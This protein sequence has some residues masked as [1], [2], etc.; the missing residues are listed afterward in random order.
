MQNMLQKTFYLFLSALLI[1]SNIQAQTSVH[2]SLNIDYKNAL[3]LFTEGKYAAATSVFQEVEKRNYTIVDK[4]DNNTDLSLLKADA[5]YYIAVCALILENDDAQELLQRFIKQHP[6]N[7]KTKLAYYQIGKY[8]YQKADYQNA[9]EWFKKVNTVDLSGDDNVE[10]KF[11][12]AYSYFI[13][14]DYASAK[15]L[16]GLIKDKKSVYAEQATYYYAIIS[17]INKDYKL[18]LSNFEKLKGSKNYEA[19]YPYYISAI[20]F[21]DQ[22]YDDVL[23]YTIPILEQTKQTNEVEMLRIVAASYFAKADYVNAIKYYELFMAKDNNS[24]QNS[25]D[26]YQIGYTYYKLQNYNKSIAQL[27]KLVSDTTAYS[28][29]GLYTLGDNYIKNK[30]KQSARNAFQVSSKLNFDRLLQEDAL[31]NFAKLSYE[32][33][34]HNIALD[35]IQNFIKKYPYSDKRNEAKTLHA[36]ILIGSKNYKTAVDILEAMPDKSE[37]AKEAYQK[38]TYFR[39][40]EF[41][42]ER[43]FENAISLFLRSL[44]YP[45][46]SEIEALATYWCAESMYEV[47]KYSEAVEK[48]AEF[49]S[50]PA[51]K[52]LSIYNY[53]NYA[54]GYAA[55]EGEN[56]SKAAVYFDK[57]LDKSD[58]DANIKTD[59]TIRLADAYF[60]AKSYSNAL[61][62]YNKIIS[63]NAKA[64]DYALFQR[65]IIQGIQNAP[66]AKIATLQSLLNQFPNSN[67]A[68]DAGFEIAY[69]YFLI[70]Q[71]E[72]AKSD[73]QNLI[74]KYP[75]TS[76]IPRALITIGLVDYDQKKD[77]EAIE[78]FKK[79]INDYKSTDEA[80]QALK[81]IERIYIDGGNA[82]EFINYANTTSI[83]NYST[84]EQDNIMFQAAYNRYLKSDWNGTIESVNAYYDKFPKPIKDKQSRFIRA[85]S[86]KNAEKYAAAIIDYE[87]ILNDWTS[88]WTEKALISISKIY[89]NNKQYNEAIVHLKKLEISSE[90]KA[91]YN[92]AI[93]NL[94]IA[95]AGIMVPDQTLKY[96]DII[97]TYEKSSD[98]D[99]LRASLFS[100]KAYLLQSDTT[101]ALKQLESVVKTNKSIIAAEAK[102]NIAEVL[103]YKK[104]YK[105]AQKTCFDLINNMPNYDYWVAKSFLLLADIYKAQN[106]KTQAIATLKS[107][108]DN[109]EGKDEI[110]E[111]A[112]QKLE[113][114]NAK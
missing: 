64:E 51:S 4:I 66:D 89:M 94:L 85:E 16:F 45:K 7:P 62:Y 35:A 65:G 105:T 112:K 63:Q 43:A 82:T 100:G 71:G 9:L 58:K 6:E 111:T 22:R 59:A 106:D 77:E 60:G 75:R 68:D 103:Y 92:Y 38:A 37:E 74:T 90:Y 33:E 30:N 10:Y 8:Y 79:V 23:K 54:L 78:V 47:R 53:A 14:E 25:Q 3:E 49:L 67:Y 107:I 97:K 20:Y 96:A 73:L 39:G 44:N 26:A 108:I 28:Q 36:K 50:Q 76:Y 56:Y 114:L 101:S 13:N 87:Y 41:F 27:G 102:Y 48:Y 95:Y 46:D 91:N 109:Y 57:F 72:K 21:L 113:I 19:S 34:F 2:N 11:K 1:V 104:D 15:P 24:T 93:N 70:G 12:T 88:E 86:Y 69:T 81:L 80:Q 32:L 61:T 31:L 40:L 18:A 99:K 83:G 84:S 42:N 52:K 5:Q 110:L 29:F 17:Y 98:E 55:L